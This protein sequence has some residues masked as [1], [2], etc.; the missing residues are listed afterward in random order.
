MKSLFASLALAAV[1]LTA[2]AATP[3][4][5]PATAP[6]GVPAGHPAMPPAGHG[7][8]APADMTKA[9]A[10]LT[11]KAKVLSVLDA[12]QFTYME[13]KDGGKSQWLVSPAIAVK[14]GNSI[15]YAD[16]DVMA[17]FHSNTLNRDFSNVVFTTRVVVDK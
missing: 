3:A 7:A 8:A 1:S 6:A 11:K 2:L 14:V 10:P 4:A 16:G 17:K 15:S 9:T 12:K 5:A 13:I